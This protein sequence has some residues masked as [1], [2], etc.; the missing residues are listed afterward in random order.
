[1]SVVNENGM[2]GTH[3][4]LMDR[5]ET[6]NGE[7]PLP[8]CLHGEKA[9]AFGKKRLADALRGQFKPDRGG[10]RQVAAVGHR[11]LG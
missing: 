1:M 10:V 3:F 2:I 6:G 8:G 11:E 5:P 7:R 4:E 9:P